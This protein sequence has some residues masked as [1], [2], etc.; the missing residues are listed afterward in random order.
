MSGTPIFAALRSTLQ[1]LT[2]QEALNILCPDDFDIFSGRS[3]I[4]NYDGGSVI[5]SV[6]DTVTGGDT[7]HTGTVVAVVGTVAEGYLVLNDCSGVFQNNE[8]ITSAAGVAVANGIL[9]P[10]TGYWT[11]F[12]VVVNAVFAALTTGEGAKV[13]T[14]GSAFAAPFNCVADI[15]ALQLTSGVIMAH[16]I[17]T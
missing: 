3:G 13:F 14:V 4:L 10:H 9:S 6:G 11:G 16:R 12:T 17:N 2:I 1:R 5:F 15:R 7:S 8:A